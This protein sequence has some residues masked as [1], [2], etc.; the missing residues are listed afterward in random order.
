MKGEGSGE[1]EAV[2]DVIILHPDLLEYGNLKRFHFSCSNFLLYSPLFMRSRP[3]ATNQHTVWP[4]L[5]SITTF[6]IIS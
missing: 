1:I 4:R 6:L 5:L 2:E 3:S